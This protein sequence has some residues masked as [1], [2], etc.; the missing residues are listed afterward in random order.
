MSFTLRT[1]TN[2]SVERLFYKGWKH[3]KKPRAKVYAVFKI[4][5]SASTLKPYINYRYAL[6]PYVVSTPVDSF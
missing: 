4:L 5:S 2:D 3:P 1:L 6:I